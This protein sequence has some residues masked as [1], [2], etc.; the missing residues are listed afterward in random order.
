MR[1]TLTDISVFE[2]VINSAQYE[3]IINHSFMTGSTACFALWFVF[4]HAVFLQI[5][6]F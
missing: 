2:V 6:N 3:Q 1:F 5:S 4:Y